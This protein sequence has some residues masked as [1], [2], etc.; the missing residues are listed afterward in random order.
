MTRQIP[1]LLAVAIGSFAL[2]ACAMPPTTVP[3][4]AVPPT[5]EGC[6]AGAVQRYVGRMADAAT[7]EAA[8]R[9][10]GARSARTLSPGQIVTMEYRGDRLNLHID[11]SRRI[12]RI[13]CG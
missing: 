13:A 1:A 7:V 12:T 8:R 11:E 4:A 5:A 6:D 3:P 2:S 10:A 9:D